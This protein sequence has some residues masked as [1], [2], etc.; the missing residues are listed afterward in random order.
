MSAVCN[1]HRTMSISMNALVLFASPSLDSSDRFK[2]LKSDSILPY[3][4]PCLNSPANS[5]YWMAE[6]GFALRGAIHIQIFPPLPSCYLTSVSFL[7]W[8]LPFLAFSSSP[9]YSTTPLSFT[10][11][12]TILFPFC[13]W[14]VSPHFLSFL[15]L[16][17]CPCTFYFFFALFASALVPSLS[18][19]FS[20]IFIRVAHSLS[21]AF[22]LLLLLLLLST[23]HLFPLLPFW[24]LPPPFPLSQAACDCNIGEEN[25]VC[26]R[27]SDR[28]AGSR[29]RCWEHRINPHTHRYTHIASSL[30]EEL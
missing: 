3:I 2:A 15:P 16:C 19:Y 5:H 10:L 12:Y 6:Q 7:L 29:V 9:V 14:F 26:Q 28:W 4:W 1:T 11:L 27:E 13:L 20:F 25:T 22:S 24:H 8:Y 23:L 30:P 18:H 17:Q 21:P